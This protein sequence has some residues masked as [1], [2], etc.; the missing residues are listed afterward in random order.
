MIWAYPSLGHCALAAL[1]LHSL[2]QAGLLQA[3]L[4]F[5]AALR[6][7]LLPAVAPSISLTQKNG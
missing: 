5:G 2:A 4:R 3:A 7:A 6:S 1:A